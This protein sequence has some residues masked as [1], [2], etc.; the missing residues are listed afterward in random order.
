LFHF[1]NRALAVVQLLLGVPLACG[2]ATVPV[3]ANHL[4]SNILTLATE[5]SLRD[6]ARLLKKYRITGAPV[7]D[8]SSL[9]GILSR[10]DLLVA[11]DKACP[12]EVPAS[13]FT[14]LMKSV[15]QF[16]V[17]EAMGP[18]PTTIH[19][20]ATLLAAAR[21]MQGKKLNRLMAKSEY[22]SMLGVISSTD[23]V[24]ALLKCDAKAAADIDPDEYTFNCEA[25][26]GGDTEEDIDEECALGTTVEAY[27]AKCLYVMRPSMSLKDAARLLRAAGV[28]GAP[29]IDSDDQLLG[30][31]SR[32]DLLKAL[33]TI[34]SE[35]EAAGGEAF[36]EAIMEIEAKTVAEIMSP[37]RPSVSITPKSTIL[38]A[39]K[40]LAREKLN[41]LMVVEPGSGELC[42]V[43]SS[44]D[45]VFAMLGC[46]H[47]LD[48]DSDDTDEEVEESRIGNLYRRGIY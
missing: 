26:Y 1:M 8:G 2:M 41:R 18:H 19:P 22:S 29:V 5:D 6:A 28:T 42:G 24:F 44:T 7:A 35:V 47:S 34:P 43:I 38:Q 14:D 12:S 30:V 33:L 48:D 21:A 23:V 37:A 15:Q 31:V 25:D 17:W 9:S 16:E 20:D 46:A 10:N 39:A 27:M 4:S 36:A 13:S 45:V 40:L 3:V 32:N 11:I